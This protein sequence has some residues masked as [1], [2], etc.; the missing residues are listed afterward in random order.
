MAWRVV[1]LGDTVWKVSP[2]AERTGNT[3]FW[4]LVLSFRSA[5]SEPASFWAAY[6]LEST[7]KS[8]L[9]AQAEKIPDEKLAEL[10]ATHL[11]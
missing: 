8:G 2:A 4:R 5:G 7:S 3:R 11:G 6:P 1:E 9:F 10:L